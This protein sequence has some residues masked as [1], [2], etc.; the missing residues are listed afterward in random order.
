MSN[1]R[2]DKLKI[3]RTKTDLLSNKHKVELTKKIAKLKVDIKNNKIGSSK[4][5][6]DIFTRRDIRRIQ[7]TG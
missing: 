6:R 5:K 7:I 4:R 3:K 2:I 1:Q